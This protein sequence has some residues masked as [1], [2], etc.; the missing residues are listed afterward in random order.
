M[1]NLSQNINELPSIGELKKRSQGLA[2]LDAIIMPD[3]EY[4]YFSF[5]CN[6][7]DNGTEMMASMRDGSGSEYFLNFTKDGVVGK[8]FSIEQL[9][10]VSLSLR[11]IP[12][13][14]S[15]FKIEPAFNINNTTF[16]FWRCNEDNEWSV[17]PKSL[18]SYPLLGFLVNGFSGYQDWAED[19]YEKSINSVVL[20]DIFESL[21]IT[22]E[23]WLTLNPE[24]SISELAEDLLEIIGK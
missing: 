16:F 13:C 1:N 12:D 11:A 3:W 18:S 23:Q 20:K 10:D 8:V 7:D 2:L 21:K 4:R 5:N 24:L 6:W 19:Y 14:F 9:K 22:E 17:S 15:S